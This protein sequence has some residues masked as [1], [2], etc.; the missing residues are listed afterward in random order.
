MMAIRLRRRLRNT[1][2]KTSSVRLNDRPSSGPAIRPAMNVPV[3]GVESQEISNRAGSAYS[4]STTGGNRRGRR[5]VRRRPA[6]R[7]ADSP[8]D[9]NSGARAGSSELDENRADRRA[10]LLDAAGRTQ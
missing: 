8:E 6:W 10:L 5:P 9:R 4:L 2:K 3:P 1:R 7:V